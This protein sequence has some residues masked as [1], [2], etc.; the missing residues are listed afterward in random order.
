MT[1]VGGASF[2]DGCAIRPDVSFLSPVFD[3]FLAV[4]LAAKA[5]P[6]GKWLS[7]AE[8]LFIQ[9]A[10]GAVVVDVVASMHDGAPCTM[11]TILF[12]P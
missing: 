10:A 7:L 5:M 6:A 4:I 8:G 9:P 2:T 11:P 1:I 3:R 12:R